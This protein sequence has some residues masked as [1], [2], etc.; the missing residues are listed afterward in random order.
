MIYKLDWV[1]THASAWFAPPRSQCEYYDLAGS[2]KK[3]P[4]T[5]EGGDL[6]EVARTPVRESKAVT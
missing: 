2:G 6:C 3:R 4:R 5:S 1:C